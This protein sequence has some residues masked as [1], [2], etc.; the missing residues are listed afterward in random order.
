MSAIA[1]KSLAELIGT[2]AMV[3]VGCGAV[4]VSERF[5]GTVAP[6]AVPIAFGLVVAAMIYAVGHIS[7]AHFNPA[8]S[9]AFAVGRHFPLPQL[10]V[11][12]TAQFFGAISAMVVLSAILPEGQ[13]WG[14]TVLSVTPW[15]GLVWEALLSFILMFV[16]VSVA[17]DTR[18]VGTMAG[19]AIGSAVALAAIVGGPVTGASM[20][21]ART[22]APAL[23]AG[24]LSNLW[25]YF[26]GPAIGAVSAAL[27]YGWLRCEEKGPEG[28]EAPSTQK[29]A[30]GC[31]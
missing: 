25:V 30:K 15:Q 10:V 4:M 22:L 20:N 27:V 3:F 13:S 1:K 29:S 17:T 24:E 19:A 6:G 7:G 18:A 23:M 14:A 28:V 8:V 9:L 5:P 21:P 11:Y 16:I 26:V 12:W 2:F 31:C